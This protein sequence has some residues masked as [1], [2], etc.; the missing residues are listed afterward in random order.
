MVAVLATVSVFLALVFAA[1]AVLGWKGPGGAAESRI[2]ALRPP[3]APDGAFDVARRRTR[4]S[5]PTLSR[6]LSTSS[7]ADRQARKLQLASVQIRVGEYLLI[8]L[9][10]SA[11]FATVPLL[12][13]G[14]SLA[15]LLIALVSALAGYMV[16]ALYVSWLS[17]RRHDRIDRQLTDLVP[18]LESSARAGFAFQ[19]AL[20]VAASQIGPPMSDELTLLLNDVNLGATVQSALL[21]LGR[22][23]GSTDLDMIITAI[24]VQRTTGGNL[25]DVLGQVG[26]TIGERESLRSEVMTFTAQQRL[27]GTILSVYPMIIG[28]ILLA[29]M[30]AL[31]SQLFTEPVG[32]AMLGGALTLQVLGFFFMRRA[33][34]VDF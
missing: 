27:T 19:Q 5:I 32:R 10:F 6:W 23:V 18:A 1:A 15:G 20:A 30:P 7:W 14:P 33:L 26:R 11:V 34:R 4:S 8:R 17:K 24:L 12:V 29:I 21:D 25:A 22:R 16:P 3:V 31:W 28:L 13:A 2:R 9:L